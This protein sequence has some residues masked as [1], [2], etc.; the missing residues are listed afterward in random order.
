MKPTRRLACLAPFFVAFSAP[1][2][3][4]ANGT[5]TFNNTGTANWSDTTKWS[6][7]TVAGGAVAGSADASADF[8]TLDITAARTV[9]LDSNRSVST[10]KF[11]DTGATGDSAWTISTANASA[12]T[13]ATSTGT[14][15][16]TIGSTGVVNSFAGQTISTAISGTQGF[17]MS[18]TNQLTLSGD[19]SN[20]S[21]AMTI[22]GG[23]LSLGAGTSLGGITSVTVASGGQ[24]GFWNASSST[25]ANITIAGTGY[26]ETGFDAALRLGNASCN[27]VLDGTVTL[28]GNATIAGRNGAGFSNTFNGNIGDSGSPYILT[29]GTTSL[30]GTYVL[31][32]TNTYTGG[33]TITNGTVQIGGAGSLGSGN[34]AGTIANA[35][36]FRYSSS[37]NQTLSGI[38]SGTGAL[39]KDTDTSSTL[40]V[41]GVNTYTGATTISAGVLRVATLA[42][43]GVASNIGAASTA[44]ANL[45]FGG[46]TLQYTGASVTTDRAFNLTAS[47]TLELTSAATLLTIANGVATAANGTAI[48]TK[49]G[50]GMLVLGGSFDNASLVL[51]VSTGE[52]DLAKSGTTTRAVAGISSVAS[53][54]IVKLTGTGG[55]QIYG[56]SNANNRGISGLDGT[57]DLNGHSESTS[58]FNGTAT[59]V[60]TNSAAATNAIWTVGE[61]NTTSAF[62]GTIQNGAGTVALVKIGTGMQTLSGSN[63]YTGS[64]TLNGGT[65]SLNY[66]SQ[67]NS[68]LSDTGLVIN[69]GTI[70]MSGDFGNHLEIVGPVT[71]N[72]VVNITRSGFN[73]AKIALGNFTN[74]GTLNVA[75]T[76]LATTTVANN[77]SGYLSGVTFGGTG[78][79]AKDG[80]G[81]IVAATS[82]T[83]ADVTRLDDG[84]KIIPNNSS[85]VRIIEGSGSIA[86]PITIASGV[87]TDIGTLL[88]TAYGAATTVDLSTT[89]GSIL[90]LGLNG[91]LIAAADSSALI[92]QNGIL[93]A[94]GAADTAGTVD[95]QNGS[96]NAVTINSQL[97]DNGSGAV[98][99]KT[100]GNVSVGSTGVDSTNSYTGGTTVNGG[101]LTVTSS[102]AAAAKAGLG[103]GTVT[104]NNAKLTLLTASTANAQSYANNFVL[105]NGTLSSQDGS[106]TYSGTVNLLAGTNNTINDVWGGKPATFT[107]TISGAGNLTITNTGGSAGGKVTFTAAN[108]YTGATTVSTGTLQFAKRV[109][110][111]N[112]TTGAWTTANLTVNSGATAVFNV[113]AA[114][115]FTSA[116]IDILKGLGSATGGFMSGSILGLD[117]TNAAGGSFTYGSIIANT[118]GG[119]NVIGLNKLGTG[120]LTLTG[121]N[122]YTGATTISADTVK[123]GG[124]GSLGSG[125]YPGTISNAGTFQYSSSVNQTL[126]GV[127]SG[128]GALIKDTGTTSTLTLNKTNTYTGGTTVN[129]GVLDLTGGGGVNGA[130]RGVATI[131]TGATLR[132]STGDATGYDATTR[133]S[134]IH[135][136]GGT[137]NVNSTANQ[138]LGSATINM[139][140]ASITGIA[141][142]NLDFFAGAS[143]LNSFGSSTTSTI[144]GT[145]LSPLRQGNTT[146]IVSQG[147]TASGID[148]DIQSV[149]KN[150]ASGDAANA[151]LNIIG[152]GTVAFSGTNTITGS[153]TKYITVSG[154]TL[155]VGNGLTTGSLGTMNVTNNATLSFNRS[156]AAGSFSNIISGS[157]QVKQIGSGTTTLTGA[158]TYTGDTTVAA[159]ILA[160]NGTAIPNAGKLVI[161]GGKVQPT[162]TEVVGTLFFGAVQQAS[163][164]WGSST[165]VPTPAH[166]DNTH[167]SGTGVVSVTTAPAGY[168]TWATANAGG[169]AADGDYDNDGV[170]NGMEFFFGATGSTFTANPALV[171]GKITWPKSATFAGTYKVETSTN[172]VTWTD[173]TASAVDN[174]TSVTYT[175]AT[176]DPARFVRLNVTVTP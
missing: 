29:F 26:G 103:T 51:A 56:G 104:V 131:N 158:N 20:L 83:Y 1:T 154:G 3:H 128:V 164:T 92:L 98:A 176:G 33:T 73:T 13:L 11:D 126:A 10:L 14:P 36:S 72:G 16:I 77:G 99:L 78:F 159:G 44:A 105:D 157:G 24:L 132:L 71:I 67:N 60:V 100:F 115:E 167:F 96:A 28:S 160:V 15:T 161:T 142:A 171:A 136:N 74:N 76:G 65:L 175:P 84:A 52:V 141:G 108:T 119:A 106:L 146:F 102:T 54:A 32:G 130:I 88:H 93:T 135:L 114:D 169:G 23:R 129:Q 58:Y 144:S 62:D 150:S 173:V 17:T 149:I 55:D 145:T 127:I 79:A 174:G 155:M 95:V 45:V 2:A 18:G 85:I 8:S 80:L 53:G 47:S 139:T 91:S 156:D 168:N 94:G 124:A 151:V 19:L 9:T 50:P 37:A 38:L 30:N 69:G 123:I 166:I 116:D 66:D 42:N 125:N 57:L 86:D 21:G 64:T 81:N 113:N 170:R 118:N 75:E 112:G 107:N 117:I 152:G 40:I 35:G 138:T 25:S 82:L 43:G 34:Y 39:A 153:A 162:G 111:Y 59:G 63:P 68:K 5:W 41:S 90:R 109:S 121:A 4:A 122:T 87:T 120:T 133:L 101:T 12:L 46:G 147:T 148:L 49:T 143:A 163:G 97:T 48:L 27:V 6:G 31:N 61:T 110:L 22:N 137:L 134:T 89:V 172:L 70:Q 165:A 7:G 140:G